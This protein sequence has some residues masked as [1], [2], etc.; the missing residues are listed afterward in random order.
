MTHVTVTFELNAPEV[1]TGSFAR[2]LR[3]SFFYLHSS[4]MYA[5]TLLDS[6]ALVRRACISERLGNK[7]NRFGLTK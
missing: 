3:E 2:H 7:R 4:L 5:Q 6:E 1:Y